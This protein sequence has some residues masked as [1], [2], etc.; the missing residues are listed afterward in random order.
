MARRDAVY[1]FILQTHSAAKV[2]Y[3]RFLWQAR[4][5]P[6]LIEYKNGSDK[7]IRL[8]GN[9][10][11]FFKSGE[12][13]QDLRV[14]TLD[15]VIIDEYRQQH[16]DLW[17]QVIRPM[18]GRRKGWA[19]FLSTANGF[20]HFFDLYAKA[21]NDQSGEWAT[22]HSPSS[23]AWWWTPEEIASA[24]SDM[25]EAEFDQEIMSNFRDMT[26]D[27]VYRTHGPHNQWKTSLWPTND[28]D[29]QVSD[30][31]PIVIG[32]DFNLSP[33]AWHLGQCDRTKIYWFDE[34]HLPHSHTQEAT[35]LLITKLLAIKDKGLLRAQPQL[36]VCGDATGSAGQRAAAAQSDYDI[37]LGGLKS[38]GFTIDNRTPSAN[39]RVKDRINTMNTHL[40][41]ADGSVSFFYNPD[42]CPALKT[43]FDRVVWKADGVLSSGLKN[44]LT[45]ASDSVGYPTCVLLPL[46]NRLEV[47]NLRI[48]V[49]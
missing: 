10:N 33:M 29:K 9:R 12:N 40:K 31:L 27:K 11:I 45:H 14:E 16:P 1:W 25:S 8:D 6:L 21:E 22:F 32:L 38:A 37:V 44:E 18:L 43:D 7:L 13:Y 34:I 17:P 20:D 19:D 28:P 39:P 42:T 41:A 49:R 23:E 4:Q 46:F 47:G 48:L 3:D 15:G 30:K 26:K 24:K 36:I 2:V 5:C 35:Q